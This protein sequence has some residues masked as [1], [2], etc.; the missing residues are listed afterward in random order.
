MAERDIMSV[1]ITFEADGAIRKAKVLDTNFKSLGDSMRKGAERTKGL[2]E[3]QKKLD[4][5]LGK[6]QDTTVKNNVAFIG[7]LAAFEAITSATNQLIS[8]QYKRIDADLA[9]GKI[10]QEEA[11]Q[12]RKNVKQY[13]KYTGMLETGIALARFG[14]VVQ[15][16]YN[17]VM[18]TTDKTTKAATLSTRAFN[19]ALKQNPIVLIITTLVALIAYLIALEKIFYKTSK[20]IDVVTDS[21][22]KL[23]EL[24]S[25]FLG[26][27][28]P[29]DNLIESE[30][31]VGRNRMNSQMGA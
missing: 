24:W 30:A 2:E 31:M 25:W 6:T 4:A 28:N 9:A 27:A 17:A 26:A 7:K 15:M 1:A 3:A 5:A 20:S 14:T 12:L 13:E 16:A 23:Q 8:A 11:E 10:T 29:F 21:L 22:K 19:F 18:A